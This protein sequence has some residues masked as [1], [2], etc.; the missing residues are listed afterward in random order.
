VRSSSV[1]R[2][3]ISLTAPTKVVLANANT[4]RDQDFQ[5]G[6]ELLRTERV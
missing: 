3:S 2:G 5:G 4:A 1:L 6:A